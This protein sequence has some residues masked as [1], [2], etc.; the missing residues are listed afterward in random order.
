MLKIQTHILGL[1]SKIMLQ[2]VDYHVM[3]RDLVLL[4]LVMLLKDLVKAIMPVLKTALMLLKDLV[5]AITPA[6]RMEVW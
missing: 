3:K 2:L 5:K 1:V 4:T 6:F